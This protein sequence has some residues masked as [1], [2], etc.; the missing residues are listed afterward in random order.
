MP[1]SPRER[2]IAVHVSG[3]NLRTG[4][5]Q[6]LNGFFR[7]ERRRAVQGRFCSRS[8]IAHERVG[9]HPG[10]GHAIRIRALGEEQLEHHIMRPSIGRAQGR[11]Q[12]RLAGIRQRPVN[13]RTLLDQILAQLRVPVKNGPVEVIVV[14]QRIE[15]FPVREQK[16]DGTHIAVVG[17]PLNER[18]SATAR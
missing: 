10:L 18:H 2:G 9:F 7:A 16:L 6:H 5:E 14:A 12:R 4:I 11:M 17:T 1:A 13:V 8:D 3:V 15:R